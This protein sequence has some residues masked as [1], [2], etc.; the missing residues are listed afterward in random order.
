[1]QLNYYTKITF[2]SFP[3]PTFAIQ[4]KQD[5]NETKKNINISYY[6]K[7]YHLSDL[8]IIYHPDKHALTYN[9]TG[10]VLDQQKKAVNYAEIILSTTDSLPLQS[11]LC[12]EDGTFILNNLNASTYLIQIKT[13][14]KIHFSQIINLS[15]KYLYRRHHS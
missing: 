9:I 14:G 6:E 12:Q 2:F 15:K 1:M 10:R 3:S 11:Q 4:T 5:K 8:H 13:L 7:Y